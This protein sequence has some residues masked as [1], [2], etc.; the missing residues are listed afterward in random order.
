[1]LYSSPCY[2]IIVHPNRSTPRPTQIPAI[3]HLNLQLIIHPN[4]CLTPIKSCMHDKFPIHHPTARS[5]RGALIRN[6][7]TSTATNFRPADHTPSTE[8]YYDG[9]EQKPTIYTHRTG[10]TPKPVE[11][12]TINLTELC[13]GI[14]IDTRETTK[15]GV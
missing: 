4:H 9:D 3:K 1:M 6:I 13:E 14:Y 15:V 8:L 7:L 2:H 12:K 5:N 10:C 11:P